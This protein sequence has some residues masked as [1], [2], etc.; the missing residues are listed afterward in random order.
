MHGV[1]SLLSVH[2]R[3]DFSSHDA[4]KEDRVGASR[5]SDGGSKPACPVH[6][7]VFTIITTSS[8]VYFGPLFDS[9][10]AYRPPAYHHFSM[11]EIC[12][13]GDSPRKPRLGI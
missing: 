11:T 7:P 13:Y 3:Y 8:S 6:G 9:A 1:V 10:T 2:L 5:L 12:D 4:G